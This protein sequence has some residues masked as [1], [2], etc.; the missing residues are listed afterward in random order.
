[1]F[2]Q[3]VT[4][5]CTADLDRSAAFYGEMLALPLALDQGGCQI[6][7]V[8]NDSFLGVC[9]CA[10]GASVKPDSVIVTLVSHDVDGWYQ[11]LTAKG[12]TLDAAPKKNDKFN[13]YHF[14]LRDP[15]GYLLE[16]QQFLD[17]AWPQPN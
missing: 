2:E 9:Q 16:I 5:L 1:M 8:S 17:P 6:F 13:I 14:F 11:R 4:F 3:Q 7:R 12:I 15:D 10:D